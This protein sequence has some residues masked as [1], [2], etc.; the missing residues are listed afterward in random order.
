MTYQELQNI[1]R[2]N[3]LGQVSSVPSLDQIISGI[4]SQYQP[5]F[6]PV[7]Y[8]QPRFV[9]EYSAPEQ[10]SFQQPSFNYQQPSQLMPTTLANAGAYNLLP[11]GGQVGG[12]GAQRFATGPQTFEQAVF[13]PVASSAPSF[14]PGDFSPVEYNKDDPLLDMRLFNSGGGDGGSGDGGSR[15]STDDAGLATTSNLTPG[16]VGA[17]ATGAGMVTGLPLGMISSLIGRGNIADAI[18]QQSYNSAVAYNNALMAEQSGLANTPENSAALAS[19]IDSL[20]SSPVGQTTA[21]VGPSGTGG[22][23]A[24]AAQEAAAMASS[25]GLSDSEIGAVAQAAAEAALSGSSSSLSDAVDAAT[26]AEAAAGFDAPGWDA[27]QPDYGGGG[28]GGGSKIICTAMNHAYGFGSFRNAIW[29]AYADKHLTKAHEVG[30]HTLFLP[31]VDFGF[32]RGDAKPKL[33]VRKILEWGTRHRSMD[34]RA[35]M[36]GTK[37]DS[38]G[39]AIRFVFEPLCYFVGK[40]KGY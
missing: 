33:V 9:Q 40:L 21:T 1:L 10:F 36:R 26:A 7:E 32:K 31:L 4:Q 35:E 34:I 27:G 25:L 38:T 30:Y 6:M 13:T 3:Q 19:L 14:K 16:I 15:I 20:S 37:R 12:Q 29:I 28:D 39:R 11:T 22:S 8:S 23:A 17:L 24:Q 18:N 2:R 5:Q